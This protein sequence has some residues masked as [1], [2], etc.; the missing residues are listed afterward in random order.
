MNR[1]RGIALLLAVIGGLLLA[2]GWWGVETAAG[3]R[4]YDEMDG[5]IPFAAGVLGALLLACAA[6]L[7]S[8]DTWRRR[9][10]ARSI[11]T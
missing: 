2:F 10:S 6:I 4:R 5:I 11:R 1:L 9:R 3:R 7:G 8:I